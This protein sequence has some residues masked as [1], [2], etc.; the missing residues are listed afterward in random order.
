MGRTLI[1]RTSLCVTIPCL[2]PTTLEQWLLQSS[3]LPCEIHYQSLLAPVYSWG[4]QGKS[5]KWLLWG[6]RGS[7]YHV[8]E[9]LGF[10]LL[11]PHTNRESSLGSFCVFFFFLANFSH[12]K[13]FLQQRAGCMMLALVYRHSYSRSGHVT[14]VN[15]GAEMQA[16]WCQLWDAVTATAVP[17]M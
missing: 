12:L 15:E 1:R 10:G 2:R 6:L 14:A 7:Q 5:F 4:N 13:L 9:I 17:D 3:H 16:A 11:L 8:G